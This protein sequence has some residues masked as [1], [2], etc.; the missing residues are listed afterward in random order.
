MA[1]FLA[2][3]TYIVGIKKI[4]LKTKMLTLDLQLVVVGRRTLKIL[5]VNFASSQ[6]ED[7][8]GDSRWF[9]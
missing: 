1:L 4:V 8:H 7:A 9:L 5:I 2:Q 3:V 6:H